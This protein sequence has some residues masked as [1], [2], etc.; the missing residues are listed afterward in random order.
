MKTFFLMMVILSTFSTTA[1]AQVSIGSVN[2]Q[3][4]LVSVKEGK[5]VRKKLKSEFESKQK[6]LREEEKKIQ[7]MQS[8]FQ[9]QS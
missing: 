1:T 5:K 7:K 8:D 9:K 3:K 2:V 6:E 4:V